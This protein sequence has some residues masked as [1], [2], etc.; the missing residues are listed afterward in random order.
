MTESPSSREEEADPVGELIDRFMQQWRA[1][2]DP[3]IE[4]YCRRYPHLAEKFRSLGPVLLAM[5]EYSTRQP[6][7]DRL[8][9][10]GVSGGDTSTVTSLRIGD[11][12]LLREIGSGGMGVVYEAEQESLGRR[13]A[14]KLLFDRFSR[15]PATLERFRREARAAAR[16]C[17]PNIVPVVGLGDDG[18]I[19]YYV[20]QYIDGIGLDRICEL[21]GRNG[22][23]ENQP[24]ESGCP[25]RLAAQQ[26]TKLSR[27][28]LFSDSAG[29]RWVHIARFGAQVADALDYAHQQGVLH[30]DV[31]PSN[32]LLD[33]HG[34]AWLT[35]FGLA[36]DAADENLTTTGNVLGTL[37]YLAPERLQGISDR[38]GDVYGLGMTLYELL[39]GEPGF[40]DS[41]PQV[42]LRRIMH[43]EPLS[44]RSLDRS[45]PRDLETIV[46][47][48][49]ARQP[50]DRYATAA[51]MAADLRRFLEGRPVLA[52]PVPR[53]K[54][55]W[56]W[57]R[58]NPVLSSM[59]VAL[60]LAITLGWAGTT[61]QWYQAV[62]AKTV[63]ETSLELVSLAQGREMAARQESEARANELQT[64]RDRLQAAF[65]LLE[66]AREFAGAR[67][68]DDAV[69]A[70]NL[71]IETYPSLA[72]ALE[73]RGDLYLRLALPEFA[74][75]DFAQAFRMRRSA[76]SNSWLRHAMLEKAAGNDGEYQNVC[77][78]MITYFEGTILVVFKLDVIRACSASQDSGVP[79]ARL[80]TMADAIAGFGSLTPHA[81]HVLALA[82]LRAGN[83]ER[84]IQL[85][86]E[87]LEL[88]PNWT[89]RGLNYPVIALAHWRRGDR[90]LA[91]ESM[92]EAS[93]KRDQWTAQLLDDE[94]A[95]WPAHQGAT[96]QWPFDPLDWIEFRLLYQEACA[97]LGYPPPAE[98]ANQ[99]VLRARS[100]A[101]L[102]MSE[103]AVA[104]Y[105]RA[106]ELEPG[107]AS[108]QLEY[109][110][111]RGFNHI[112]HGEYS[113]AAVDYASC[114]KLRPDDPSLL[115]YHAIAC[116]WAGDEPAY[117][118]ACN[119]MLS[120][121]PAQPD[122]QTA[123][124]VLVTCLCR[125]LPIE[126]PDQLM[127]LAKIAEKAFPDSIRYRAAACFRLGRFTEALACFENARQM[128]RLR[129]AD[130]CLLAMTEHQLGEVAAARASL[131]AAK[132]W[133]AEADASARSSPDPFGMRAAWGAWTE[134]PI[135]EALYR[136]AQQRVERPASQS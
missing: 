15:M 34:Q 69:A 68:W 37:R 93:L 59:G 107:R 13:V 117:L 56:R 33:R 18:G 108:I 85:S 97:E 4:D 105:A 122:S 43:D 129:A 88:D 113:Q 84:A 3:S 94:Q 39:V 12:T 136:E 35:D 77:R 131:A 31:K 125:P 2:D 32:L 74:A 70:Y 79:P 11:Y 121:C 41:D 115:Q 20:M 47:T 29:P 106:I 67:H 49:I 119:Q 42:L 66:D 104:S 60:G 103:Q 109:L 102:R 126:D 58:R 100:L 6:E 21:A 80:A 57:C 98:D 30:R 52:R 132:A 99:H 48:S 51:E 10:T 83:Y 86:Q 92:R 114:V 26:L 112:S 128:A 16:L 95:K 22:S 133:M 111:C 50:K 101:G 38:R 45:I 17:H 61:Y 87:S 124:T 14:I 78:Q 9:A 7:A 120:C 55:C 90:Q 127:T 116:L 5:E 53:L 40:R 64:S 54:K 71:A 8:A 118:A 28:Y 36:R 19:N 24:S 110:R 75:P 23:I 46:V 76:R 73:E 135:T 63:A 134:R 81:A 123:L 72:V 25:D 96:A 1:G 65:G 130:L 27:E 62:R 44:P 82:Q 89:A 91:A